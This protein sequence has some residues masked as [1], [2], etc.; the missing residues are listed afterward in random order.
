MCIPPNDNKSDF[1]FKKMKLINEKYHLIHLSMGMSQ[2]YIVAC[3]NGSTFIRVGSNIF[4]ERN[5]KF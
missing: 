2:D 3:K 4:G 1:Y 5:I